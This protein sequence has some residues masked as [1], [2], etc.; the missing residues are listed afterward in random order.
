[1]NDYSKIKN[2]GDDTSEI[3]LTGFHEIFRLSTQAEIK[4]GLFY[5]KVHIIIEPY[6]IKAFEIGYKDENHPIIALD[7]DMVT[8]SIGLNKSSPNT[9]NLY[10]LGYKSYFML[11]FSNEEILKNAAM[12]LNYYITNSEGN[13]R[14]MMGVS[15]RKDFYKYY[16]IRENDFKNIAKTGDILIF[17]GFEC[18]AKCQR[19]FTQAHYDHVALLIRH[20]DYLCVYESTSKDGVKLRRWAEFT[21]SHW[22]LL[23]DKMV[24]RRLIIKENNDNEYN[25]IINN[26][27]KKTD[28][29]VKE[30]ESKRYTINLCSLCCSKK[31]SHEM[32]N[33]WGETQGFF[34]SQLVA[35]AYLKCGIIEYNKYSGSFLPGAFSSNKK[36]MF[37]KSF[38]LSPEIIID[39]TK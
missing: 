38:S 11:R 13:E 18:A 39:F 36:L 32:E 4:I 1:M 37:N 28:E 34:C 12:I 8:A 26:I 5:K 31:V 27:I 10:V 3:S 19:F 20:N 22:N 14:N 29:F 2:K 17:R 25:K 21:H 6:L 7:F 9:L 16:Y 23:Y 35:A 24:F 30:T 15:L 33:R